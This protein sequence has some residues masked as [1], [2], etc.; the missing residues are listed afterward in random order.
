MIKQ[1]SIILY[2]NLFNHVGIRRCRCRLNQIQLD[3][4]IQLLVNFLHQPILL[5][6]VRT[7]FF[8]SFSYRFQLPNPFHH[9]HLCKC[10]QNL[11]RS[12]QSLH[13]LIIHRQLS[14]LP[15][16]LMQVEAPM[17]VGCSKRKNLFPPLNDLCVY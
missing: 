11:H 15:I 16:C 3:L 14:T 8:S 2:L 5:P 13:I 4:F 12:F 1:I 10:I 9:K 7:L 6:R 17:P